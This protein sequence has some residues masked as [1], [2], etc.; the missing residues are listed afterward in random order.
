MIQALIFSD[1]Y[2]NNMDLDDIFLYGSPSRPKWAEKT[3]QVVGDLAGNPLDPRKTRYQ[4][5][6]ASYTSEIAIFE[7]CY[8]MIRSNP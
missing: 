6:N 4:F 5:R 3:I 7:N 2:D 8:M 1:N